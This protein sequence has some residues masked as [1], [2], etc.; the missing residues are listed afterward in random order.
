MKLSFQ[1]SAADGKIDVYCAECGEVL[2]SVEPT[3]GVLILEAAS[4]GE[5]AFKSPD[6]VGSGEYHEC[7]FAH[8]HDRDH[9]EA[10]A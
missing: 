2:A 3:K 10:T 6:D 9:H 7:N 4:W 8:D 1:I 5:I